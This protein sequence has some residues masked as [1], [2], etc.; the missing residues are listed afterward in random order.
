MLPAQ[1]ALSSGCSTNSYFFGT[2]LSGSFNVFSHNLEDFKSDSDTITFV[3]SSSFH[4]CTVKKVS[5]T[6][7]G[8]CA[9]RQCSLRLCYTT[10]P[11]CRKQSE[12]TGRAGTSSSGHSQP[13]PQLPTCPC[14]VPGLS[15]A[16]T[17]SCLEPPVPKQ[18]PHC[19]T[20]PGSAAAVK[21]IQTMR[22]LP[23]RAH[24]GSGFLNGY[25]IPFQQQQLQLSQSAVPLGPAQQHRDSHLHVHHT[26]I[27][28]IYRLV[29]SR[30][31]LL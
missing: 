5:V 8:H 1:I 19:H 22:H 18:L 21:Q 3:T 2:N 11:T 10:C 24:S 23:A 28:I 6:A 31:T 17:T 9:T 27:F 30:A 16:T 15:A 29:F 12:A 26:H 13:R 20:G 7:P 4:S 14:S 25:R